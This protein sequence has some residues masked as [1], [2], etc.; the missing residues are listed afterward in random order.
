MKDSK[1][2]TKDDV[3]LN[4]S[5]EELETELK[6]IKED[7]SRLRQSKESREGKG[8]D[9]VKKRKRLVKKG[10]LK[11]FERYTK[12]GF[13][14][15]IVNLTD[16]RVQSFEDVGYSKVLDESGKEVRRSVG[17]GV[18][19]VLM[20]IPNKLHQEIQDEKEEINAEYDLALE[21]P[22]AGLY[23]KT[24]ESRVSH[25]IDD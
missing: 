25:D 17:G 6:A 5:N 9:K 3:V 18:E 2:K 4:K 11:V 20:Q 22:T 7:I 13:K 8:L 14:Y 23:N 10:R 1:D 16:D 19:A 12:E 21:M 15:R 24:S